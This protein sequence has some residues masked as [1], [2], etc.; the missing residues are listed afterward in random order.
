MEKEREVM[1]KE[2]NNKQQ[3]LCCG[4]DIFVLLNH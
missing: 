2:S 4:E 1:E 3:W